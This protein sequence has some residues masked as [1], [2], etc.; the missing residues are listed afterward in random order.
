MENF[1]LFLI[2]DSKIEYYKTYR[3]KDSKIV[4][5]EKESITLN[6]GDMTMMKMLAMSE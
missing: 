2:N 4:S 3:M 6:A 5:C 1:D